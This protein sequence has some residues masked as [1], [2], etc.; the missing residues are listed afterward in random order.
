MPNIRILELRSRDR[1]DG[2][3]GEVYG[4]AGERAVALGHLVRHLRGLYTV[5]D[6]QRP[7]PVKPRRS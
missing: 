4:A 7:T 3:L 5:P 6:L 2:C 1:L